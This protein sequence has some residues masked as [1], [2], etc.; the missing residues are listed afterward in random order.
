MFDKFKKKKKPSPISVADVNA[1]V[2]EFIM[3]SQINHG[4]EISVLIGCSP[5]SDEVQIREER[6]SDIRV[7]KL[8]KLVPLMYAYAHMLAEGTSEFQRAEAKNMS[9]SL[10][11]EV[12]VES[13]KMM[14]QISF[15]TL[16]GAVS[17]MVDM[18][19]LDITKKKPKWAK[20]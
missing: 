8:A 1:R 4:H 9:K 19:I 2:R 6:E 16:V 14:E 10:P 18:G 12:W 15:A 7:D 13:K 5:I 17:Q 3:D 11:D 20:K